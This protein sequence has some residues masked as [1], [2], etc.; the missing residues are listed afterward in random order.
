[1]HDQFARLTSTRRE[2]IIVTMPDAA[3]E[4]PR[5]SEPKPLSNEELARADA[6]ARRLHSELRSAVLALPER[7][8]GATGM[9]RHL[10]IERT[11]CQRIVTAISEPSV[12]PALL[13]RVPGIRGLRQFVEACRAARSSGDGGADEGRL[14]TLEAAIEQFDNLLRDLGGSQ[15]ALIRRISAV[16]RA[17]QGEPDGEHRGHRSEAARRRIFEGAAD[18][19]GRHSDVNIA[20]YAFRP[21]ADDPDQ[22]ERALVY[23]AIGHR[24]RPDAVPFVVITG[25]FSDTRSE[26]KPVGYTS[27]DST[28]AKGHTPQA[29]LTEFSSDP[30]P[31]VTSGGPNGTLLQTIDPAATADG[32]AVDILVANYSRNHGRH[33]V[34]EDIPI[35]EVWTLTHYPTKYLL[36]DVYLHRDMA[37]MC[38]PS[39]DLHL[40]RPNLEQTLGDRW[41]TRVPHGPRLEILGTGIENAH[42]DVYPRYAEMSRYFFNRLDWDPGEFIGFRCGLRYPIWRGGYCMSFD[43][44]GNRPSEDE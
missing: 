19:A 27:L 41:Y 43:F 5:A 16:A 33:P 31:L 6:V 1:M 28:P 44:S 34:L 13:S 12:G 21:W 3:T 20:L 22:I 9:A 15:S 32:A 23:G 26:N 7:G 25:H 24:A 4:P 37:R 35:E 38:I 36:F 8:R 30:P 18:V 29:V 2:P 39:L 14:A 10:D 17:R 11:T 40:W 42:S